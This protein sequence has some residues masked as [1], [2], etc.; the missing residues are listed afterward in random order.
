[1]EQNPV[2]LSTSLFCNKNHWNDVL[3][4]GIKPFLDHNMRQKQL[5]LYNVEFNYIRGDNIRLSLQTQDTY[6][7]ELAKQT[8]EYFKKFFSQKNYPTKEYDFFDTVFMPFPVN[9]IQYGLYKNKIL[10]NHNDDRLY[11]IRKTLSDLMI[12]VLSD[13]VIDEEKILLFAFYLMIIYKK[14]LTKN[15][16]TIDFTLQYQQHQVNRN[17]SIAE[18]MV[19][20]TYAENKEV[21][22]EIAADLSTPENLK[23]NEFF[24]LRDW[25]KLCEDDVAATIQGN[26]EYS[27]LLYSNYLETFHLINRQLAITDN[28]AV[29]LLYFVSQITLSA[30]ET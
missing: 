12:I 19:A 23:D 15:H 27:I 13:D 22:Q 29:M 21:L 18:G 16:Y 24:L 28:M 8:D 11:R 4:N 1:M 26:K 10:S 3:V 14:I 17:V 30:R 7:E 9:T 20:E 6:A 2:W 25:I 5:N